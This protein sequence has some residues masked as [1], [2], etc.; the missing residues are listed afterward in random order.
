MCF[1]PHAQVP[2][3]AT[4]VRTANIAG[5]VLRKAESAASVSRASSLGAEAVRVRTVVVQF[6]FARE[7]KGQS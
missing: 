3:L 2:I 5:I 6:E 1:P 4:L 7:Q